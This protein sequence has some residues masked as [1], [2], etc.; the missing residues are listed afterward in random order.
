MST[1]H[2]IGK[3]RE[4]APQPP[5]SSHRQDTLQEKV[6]SPAQTSL[7]PPQQPPRPKRNRWLFIGT[8]IAALAIILSLGIIFIPGLIRP[9]GPAPTCPSGSDS[10][11][12]W[13]T[14]IGT[15]NGERHVER[16]SCAK[17]TQVFRHHTE[18]CVKTSFSK[19]GQ[20]R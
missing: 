13:D 7:R 17:P 15:N 2:E 6:A 14:I 1:H 19:A 18:L 4:T 5:A 8:V 20:F 3:E 9:P 12:H 11:A 16:V 10:S